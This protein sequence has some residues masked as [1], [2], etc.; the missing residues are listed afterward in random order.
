MAHIDGPTITPI[1]KMMAIKNDLKSRAAGRPIFDDWEMVEIRIAGN[2]DFPVQPAW[3][4]SHWETDPESGEQ[5]KV[6]YA[7]RFAKQYRQFKERQHQTRSGTPLDYLTFL[8]EGKR[9]E[10]RA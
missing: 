1:F 4:F 5:I 6:T 2:K 7:E 10:L 8:T 9:A 3:M